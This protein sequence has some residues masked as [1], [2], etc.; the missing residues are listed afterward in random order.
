MRPA[1]HP[2]HR[3]R[4]L[5]PVLDGLVDHAVTLGELQ[6]QIELVLRGVGVDL[7]REAAELVLAERPVTLAEVTGL[8]S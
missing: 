2:L 5:R 6:Q 4:N 7:E 3:H 8:L 1:S